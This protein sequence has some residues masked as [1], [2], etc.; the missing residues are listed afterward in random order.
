MR[1]DMG[2]IGNEDGR[3]PSLERS[4]AELDLLARL[5]GLAVGF[6]RDGDLARLL[7]GALAEA[8][9][10]AGADRGAIQV[11]DGASGGLRLAAQRG[12]VRPFLEHVANLRTG[13]GGNTASRAERHWLVDDVTSSEALRGGADR[14][15]LL[16]ARVRALVVMPLRAP[17]GGFLGLISAF[18]RDAPEP[19]PARLDALDRV[20]EL[21]AAA[22]AHVRD[23][24]PIPA[25]GAEPETRLRELEELFHGTIENLPVSLV[26]CD[27]AARVLYVDPALGEM[28]RSVCGIAPAALV[29]KPGG[30]IWPP[31]VWA[32][33]EA[34]L[35]KAVA[36]GQRQTYDLAFTLPSGELSH[37]H[38]IVLPLAGPDGEVQRVLGINHDVTEQRRLLDELRG[39]D[40]RKG[41]F[42][43]LLSHE[44]RNPLSAIRSSLYVLEREDAPAEPRARANRDAARGLIDRQ[45]GHLVRLVDDLLDVTRLSQN[46][47][48]LQRRPLDLTRLAREAIEDNR[49]E[50]EARGVRLE[51]HVAAA[52][53]LASVDAVRV[54]QVVANLL[55]NAAKFTPLGGTATVSLA[56][57]GRVAV[58][59]VADTGCGIE[60]ALLPRVFEPFVQAERT[61]DRAGGGL[62]LGLALARGLVELHGGD[63]EARSDGQ[64]R[65]ATFVVRLPL[66]AR[67]EA[68]PGA[69]AAAARA[70][71]RRRV[72]VIDDDRD[73]ANGLKLALEIDAHEVAVA[74]DGDEGLDLARDFKPDFVL[75]DVGMPG[76]DG[77]QVAQA[78]RA[79]PALRTTFLVALT[80]FAQ[81]AD[82][83]KARQA[84]FDEHLAKPANMA[85]INALLAR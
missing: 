37:R 84:G 75:C 80:G 18:H 64:G 42:I 28:V 50:L 57:E 9:A 10:I 17:D 61:L 55:S 59:T 7:D 49:A 13:L 16:A 48:L 41:E 34:A 43:G 69:A 70:Q 73:V 20:A 85:T 23:E 26:L 74:Y 63:I 40:R 22:L 11:L 8:L 30:E 35:R 47:M 5:H 77:Y 58:L 36:T 67:A 76:K 81:A 44:L 54:T 45:V 19:T 51:T 52:P 33:L 38:W 65:G 27:R 25:A 39:A 24:R 56:G 31:F 46:K 66:D 32:P 62:G 14:D 1:P 78:F 82:R 6:L 53:L 72:L 3:H 12:L 71:G 2:G 21:C 15:A 83:A 29:G 68:T 60:P 79:D 4:R